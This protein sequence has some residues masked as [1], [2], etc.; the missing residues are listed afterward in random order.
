M[1]DELSC[2]DTCWRHTTI[3]AL[4]LFKTNEDIFKNEKCKVTYGVEYIYLQYSVV[5]NL[6]YKI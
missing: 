2:L 5:V 6:S 3:D 1:R 4:L